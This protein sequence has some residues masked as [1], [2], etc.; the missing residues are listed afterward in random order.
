MIFARLFT[1]FSFVFSLIALHRAIVTDML[2]ATIFVWSG[3]AWGF[4]TMEA[5][6]TLVRKKIRSVSAHNASALYCGLVITAV[7]FVPSWFL[8]LGESWWVVLV[9]AFLGLVHLSA[10]LPFVIIAGA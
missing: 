6:L 9:I 5:S 1:G 2:P 10:S 7:V 8:P 4:A 3:M